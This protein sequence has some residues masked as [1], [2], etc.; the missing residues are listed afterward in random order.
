MAADGAGP[1]GDAAAA[2][3]R[4]ACKRALADPHGAFWA[5]NPRIAEDAARRAG[6]PGALAGVTVAVKDCFDVAGLP[7]TCGVA[8][9][10]APARHDAAAVARL[11]DA[12][13]VAI[14]KTAMDPLGWSVGGQAPGF[15]PCVSPVDPRLSPGGSSS[16]SAVA[17]AAGLATIG[18]GTDV[19]GSVRVPASF[20][21]IVGFKP[22]QQAIPLDGAESFVPAF[23]QAGV[24]AARVDDCVAA[25]EVLSGQ[26]LGDVGFDGP[27][28]VLTDFCDAADPAVAAVIERALRA[29][30]RAGERLQPIGLG[31]RA[32]GFGRLL[33]AGI[34]GTWG[35]RVDRDPERFSDDVRRSVEYGRG[36][37]RAE[38]DRLGS[39]YQRARQRAE[40]RFAGLRAVVCPTVSIP[41]P[42]RDDA[43]ADVAAVTRL[44][45]DFNA[46][47]WAAASVP[48]GRDAAGRPVGL[49]IAAPPARAREV[50]AVARIAERALAGV[51]A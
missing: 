28:G 32:E 24:L 27:L 7:T 36:L 31:W 42:D 30:E 43:S 20:C 46:L 22:A 45:R 10:P 41:V 50:L 25:Y 38:L 13:A 19:A 16:G 15:P 6:S 4:A 9:P 37:E 3:V 8:G 44:T 51:A 11:S 14:G 48:A 35:E 29:L 34:A 26:P 47:G 49:Q 21:G 40:V 18:L 12:G 39:A 1:G 17:V 33:A 5:V 23:D 2:S